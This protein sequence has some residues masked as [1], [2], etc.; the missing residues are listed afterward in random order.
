MGF[1]LLCGCSKVPENTVYSLEDLKGKKIGVQL[2]TTGDV[3]AS[4]IEGAQVQRFNKGKDAIVALQAGEID[5]VMLDDG[6]ANVFAGEF[7]NIRILEESYAEEEYG[8]VVKKGNKEL[9]DKI[10]DA[11]DKIEAD[12]TL[13]EITKNWIYDGASESLYQGEDKVSHANGKLVVVTNAEFP[14]YESIVGEE[15]TGFDID[16]MKAVCDVLDMELEIEN[17]AFDSILSA[18]DRGIADVGAAAMSVT[19]ERLKQVDFSKTYTTAKQVILVRDNG[20]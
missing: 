8:L 5:A 13:E 12:G 18:V 17:I 10:N 2:K 7:E 1:M 3:Y 11:L 6:P 20:K 4:E 15:V 19:D 14:P 9:L 16:L